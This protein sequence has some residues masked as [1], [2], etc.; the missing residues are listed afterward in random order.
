[1]DLSSSSSHEIS[2]YDR[3]G[4][5]DYASLHYDN[6][7]PDYFDFTDSGGDCTNFVSQ[8]MHDGGGELMT[9]RTNISGVTI[10]GWYYFSKYDHATGWT[11]VDQLYAFLIEE[12]DLW[13][14]GPVGAVLDLPS[15]LQPG[16]LIQYDWKD[17]G[18]WVWDH[19]VMVVNLVNGVPMVVG[20]SPDW[21]Y[22]P[23]TRYIYLHYDPSYPVSVRYI[24]IL[25]S[26]GVYLPIIKNEGV[27]GTYSVMDYSVPGQDY[28]S[29][30]HT[31]TSY[32]APMQDGAVQPNQAYPAP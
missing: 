2:Y 8:A 29:N 24:H 11:S 19:S 20:R 1:M 15:D 27:G 17:S 14:L 28:S 32:P 25:S 16:D 13:T 26:P 7:N 4:A 18:S 5:V 22:D 9:G 23:Y 12:K 21:F 3:I 31:I 6:P 10:G 30:T